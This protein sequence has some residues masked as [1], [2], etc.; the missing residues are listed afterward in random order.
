[1]GGAASVALFMSVHSIVRLRPRALPT[2]DGEGRRGARSVR[3]VLR[4][5][6]GHT[7][8]AA[9][10]RFA[11]LGLPGRVSRGAAL[12]LKRSQAREVIPPSRTATRVW[13]ELDCTDWCAATRRGSVVAVSIHRAGSPV[14]GSLS[15]LHPVVRSVG[16]TPPSL[17]QD[18]NTVRAVQKGKKG[19]VEKTGGAAEKLWR[20]SSGRSTPGCAISFDLHGMDWNESPAL[21]TNLYLKVIRKKRGCP[22]SRA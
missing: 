11:A 15:R 4:P 9:A 5:S 19:G 3:R 10:Q 21:A 8:S 20:N 22:P 6:C 13:T 16:C 14:V 18:A 12:R 2:C 7:S 1:V 17:Q